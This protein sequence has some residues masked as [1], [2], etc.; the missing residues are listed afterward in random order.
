MSQ[1]RTQSLIEALTNI[2]VG[3]ALSFG[4]QLLWFP[5]IGHEL[6]LVDN[7]LTTA[8]FTGV[9]IV[10]SYFVRRYFNYKQYVNGAREEG[11]VK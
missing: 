11:R 5:L 1:S 9:S 7:A 4:V 3:L 10:R 2:G 6:T 8:V